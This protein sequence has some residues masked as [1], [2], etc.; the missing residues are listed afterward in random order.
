[1]YKAVSP[2]V[3]TLSGIRNSPKL[4]VYANA[5]ASIFVH[6]L[7]SPNLTLA[8]FPIPLKALIPISLTESGIDISLIFEPANAYAPIS[9]S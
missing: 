5:H 4:Y 8:R 7:F 1:M 6:L 9:E 3:V 2:I